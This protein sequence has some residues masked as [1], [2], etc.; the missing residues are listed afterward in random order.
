[1]C[2]AIL[3]VKKTEEQRLKLLES[4]ITNT[5]DAVL[6]ADTLPLEKDGVRIIYTNEAFERITGFSSEEVLGKTPEI[7]KSKRKELTELR[8][9]IK[10]FESCEI[11]FID[12]RKNG[13]S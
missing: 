8:N 5:S 10:N 9:S 13:D 11:T 4:V 2:S 3:P 1:M 6:I 12:Y 7:L